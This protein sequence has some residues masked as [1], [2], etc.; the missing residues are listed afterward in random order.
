VSLGKAEMREVNV[1]ESDFTMK[2]W[3]IV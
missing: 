1:R 3:L 2:L